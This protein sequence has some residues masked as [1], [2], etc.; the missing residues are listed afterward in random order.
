MAKKNKND[1]LGFLV[2][3]ILVGLAGFVYGVDQHEKRKAEQEQNREVLER[4]M[5]M[6]MQREAELVQWQ[7]ILGPKNDQVR[8][9]AQ[10][11][12]NLRQQRNDLEQ[13]ITN[14]RAA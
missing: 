3:G 11:V 8:A 5:A 10:E 1:G 6:L 4:V 2:G 12:V 13:R 14:G 7:A 9:L